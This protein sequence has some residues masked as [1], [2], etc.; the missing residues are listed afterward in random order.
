MMNTSVEEKLISFKTLE[1]KIFDY[2]C[3]LGRE[4]TRNVLENYDKELFVSR[5]TKQFR[6]KGRRKTSIKTVYGEVEYSR[7]VY[8]DN[9][10]DGGKKVYVYLLD[11][12]MQMD[13]IGLIS[14][15]LAEKIAMTVTES[16]YRVSADIISNTCGQR[17][18]AGGVWNMMQRLGERISEEEEYAVKQMNADQAEGKKQI[19]VLFEEMDGVWLSMQDKDHKEMKKQEMKVA[20]MYEGWDAEKEKQNRST[21]VG[22]TMLAGMERSQEFHEKREACIRKKYDADEIGQRILNGDGGSWIKEPYDPETIF[23]LDRYHI[24]QEILRKIADKKAQQ[25]IR[26]LFEADKPDEMLEYI[27]TYATSVES[28][29]E[30]D[31][32]S[33]KAMEL[34]KYLNNNKEGLLPY[35]K[36]GV[37][38]PE[39]KEGII[40][41]EM[42]VQEN[43]NCTAITMRM[44]HRRMRWSEKGANNLAKALYRKENRELIETIDRYT[45]GLVFTLQM[46]EIIETLSAAKAP[47]KDGK[48]NPY[49]DVINAHMPILDAIQTASRK[50][51]KKAFC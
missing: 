30:K 43:Q 39:P 46:Q 22:K 1:Q 11:Q 3:E 13:K 28:S 44:K 50:A 16:P 34:Y 47:K 21:L 15:N 12:A 9:F 32:R 38:I 31:N 8:R 6:D 29:D 41:K 10:A 35:D 51:F 26:E 2:V 27:Q 24:Y 33:K 37:K 48:G 49:A 20:T 5:D 7:R 17:I 14:T 42:G 19:P 4:I 25:E 18:S 36:R 40:Y 45:D 23:Q